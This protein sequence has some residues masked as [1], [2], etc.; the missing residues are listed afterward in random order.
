MV[1][2]R[3]A[4]GGVNNQIYP[5][6]TVNLG[7]GLSGLT[8]FYAITGG[9]T[10]ASEV[11]NPL[12]NRRQWTLIQHMMRISFNNY[13]DDTLHSFRDDGVTIAATTLTVPAAGT[14]FFSTGIISSVIAAGSDVGFT[15]DF[16][17]STAGTTYVM[18][19]A[20]LEFNV[21]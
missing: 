14:G 11:N 7:T 5:V 21:P 6:S 12:L 15:A 3:F 16:A 20:C 17:A 2:I 4:R 18:H 13:D 9:G 8:R 19:A 10:L 1:A